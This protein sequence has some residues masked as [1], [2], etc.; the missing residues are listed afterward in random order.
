MVKELIGS[1]SDG[2]CET[3]AIKHWK[4][5]VILKKKRKKHLLEPQQPEK[6]DRTNSYF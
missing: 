4:S 3:R 6:L 5:C 1:V 2:R